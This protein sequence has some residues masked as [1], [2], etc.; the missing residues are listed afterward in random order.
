[1]DDEG[2]HK[3]E[4]P[5]KRFGELVEQVKAKG[6]NAGELLLIGEVE[7][8]LICSWPSVPRK[9]EEPIEGSGNPWGWVK[10]NPRHTYE[11]LWLR[12]V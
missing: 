12:S 6:F 2:L 9:I 7:F 8:R 4:G 3:V 1:M 5:E 10:F 11:P